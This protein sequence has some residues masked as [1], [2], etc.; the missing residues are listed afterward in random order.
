MHAPRR[1]VLSTRGKK[2]SSLSSAKKRSIDDV[3]LLE[4]ALDRERKARLRAEDLLETMSSKIFDANELLRVQNR[5]LELINCTSAIAEEE[6]DFLGA[7]KKFL[8]AA[9]ESIDWPLGHVYLRE[10]G[11][12]GNLKSAKVWAGRLAAHVPAFVRKSEETEFELGRGLPGRAAHTGN[13]A[14]IEEVSLDQD[15]LRS[16]EASESGIVSAF[17]IPLQIRGKTVAVFEFFHSKRVKFDSSRLSAV[18]VAAR[19]LSRL[20]ERRESQRVIMENYRKLKE[21]KSQLVESEKLASIG[22]MAAGIAHEINNPLSFVLAN[23]E[24][25]S[26]FSKRLKDLDQVLSSGISDDDSDFRKVVSDARENFDLSHWASDFDPLISDM[27]AGLNRVKEIVGGL[28]SFSQTESSQNTEVYLRQCIE[29]VLEGFSRSILKDVKLKVELE[30]IA[31]IIGIERQLTRVI[32]CLI[33]NSVDAMDKEKKEVAIK[34]T[35][36]SD[37]YAIFTLTDNGRGIPPEHLSKVFTP[38]FTSQANNKRMGL[39]L[40]ISYGIIRAHRGEILI[41]SEIKVGTR[42]EVR[43]PTIKV[44][45]RLPES[46]EEESE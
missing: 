35:E 36:E 39:G 9:V 15:F 20:I 7:V 38:F 37:G 28:K 18:Q 32:E 33:Q 8:D 22:V 21:T 12:T 31:P 45:D 23:I 3:E 25:L 30:T 42:V 46:V 34:L 5:E 27:F 1:R 13:V 40:P 17:A 43:L 44:K 11:E 10:K 4:R 16:K 26:E 14:W 41:Q 2:E 24:V 6:L 19:Q 29:S